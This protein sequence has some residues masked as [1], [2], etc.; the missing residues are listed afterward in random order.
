MLFIHWHLL[1]SHHKLFSQNLDGLR[2]Q[3]CY[4]ESNIEFTVEIAK[5]AEKNK[6]MLQN[7]PS[8][9][10]GASVCSPRLFFP[11]TLYRVAIRI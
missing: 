10:C 3:C 4:G 9:A 5:S 7:P 2:F 1:L 6:F 8:L 11:V